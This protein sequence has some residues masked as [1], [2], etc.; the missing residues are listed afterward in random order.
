MS[1]ANP[2]TLVSDSIA[3]I[4]SLVRRLYA[5]VA[6]LERHFPGRKFT[7]DG[8]LVG[9]IGE[10]LAAHHYGLDLLPA[11]APVHD[12]I[13]SD[14]RMVQVKATQAKTVALRAEPEHLL[15]LRLKP[16]GSFDEVYNGPGSLVWESAGRMQKN[17]QRPIGVA[18]LARIMDSVPRIERVPLTHEKKTSAQQH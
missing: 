7:L 18:K 14:G 10:V 3:A 17:G 6:E 16:D 4:P 11:S 5:V 2:I 15:V 1:E 13:A 9:S 8:H 12:A